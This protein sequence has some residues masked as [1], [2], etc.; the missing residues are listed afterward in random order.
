M[1][2]DL[3]IK[4]GLVCSSK[5]VIAGGLAVKDGIIIMIG[6]DSMLPDALEVYDAKGNYIFPG[7]VEPHCHLGGDNPEF[8][9]GKWHRDI[10]TESRA[11]AQGGIT[12]IHSTVK[13]KGFS[14]GMNER[15]DVATKSL[16]GGRAYA[17]FKFYVQAFTDED[18][19]EIDACIENH[20]TGAYKFLLGYRG[21]A[22]ERMGMPSSGFDTGMM[23]KNFSKVAAAGAMAMVHCEDPAV[24]EITVAKV[25]AEIPDDNYNY[26]AAFNRSQPPICESIDLCKSAYVANEV[27]C[28]L[29]VVHISAEETV[30]DLEYFKKK[31]FDITGETCLHYLMFTCDDKKA[32]EDEKWVRNSKVNPP[33]R[34]KSDQDR[35]WKA[36]ND[37]VITQ[38]GTD[39]VCYNPKTKY[40]G[41][42]WSIRVGVG[43]GM[44][45]S[46]QMMLSEGVNKNRC[47]LDTVRKIMCENNA[48][49]LGLYPKKGHLGV[50]ADADV[51]I[52]DLDKEW[53][54]NAEELESSHCGSLYEGIEGKGASIAT[55]LRGKLIA[56]NGKIIAEEGNGEEITYFNKRRLTRDYK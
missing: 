10:Y 50:G 29:Y 2:A 34:E 16:E 1:K 52:I 49:A 26:T 9:E 53:K 56:E 22:A 32:T 20:G 4:N 48:K 40:E 54:I 51:I 18:V 17:D 46:L 21:E 3:V 45:V 36:I 33:I 28:P 39:H 31:G 42:F 30:D 47:S 15:M 35:L 55:F 38:L 24:S 43:D 44:S 25:K 8:E 11:A 23:Y 7:V 13:I 12:T 6:P 27:N 5:E 14:M 37:G 19:D 41:D